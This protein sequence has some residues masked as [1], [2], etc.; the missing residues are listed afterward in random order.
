[1]PA[2]QGQRACGPKALSK[3]VEHESCDGA[4]HAD[5]KTTEN[6]LDRPVRTGSEHRQRT[7]LIRALMLKSQ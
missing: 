2:F 3:T 5:L 4:A 6:S 1:M 7:S